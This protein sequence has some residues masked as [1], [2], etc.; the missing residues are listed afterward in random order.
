V[1]L[2]LILPQEDSP[3]TEEDDVLAPIEI[4][5]VE[6]QHPDHELDDKKAP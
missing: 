2:N 4:V 3:S 6:V 5:D 1:V